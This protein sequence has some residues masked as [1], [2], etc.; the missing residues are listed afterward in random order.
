MIPLVFF[1]VMS[2]VMVGVFF[3]CFDVM[4]LKTPL[5]FNEMV[6]LFYVI[7]WPMVALMRLKD[8]FF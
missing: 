6:F 8:T 3:M 1:C 7:L 2:Y 5:M 4:V